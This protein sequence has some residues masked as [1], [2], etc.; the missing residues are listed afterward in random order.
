MTMKTTSSRLFLLLSCGQAFLRQNLHRL[1]YGDS[2]DAGI[3]IDPSVIVERGIFRR[4]HL[5]QFTVG[6]DL[7]ARPRSRF[8][9]PR[10]SWDWGV[11]PGVLNRFVMNYQ[12]RYDRRDNED[13]REG[14]A[15]KSDVTWSEVA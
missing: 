10:Q 15:E 5:A 14:N 9:L 1:V 4:P 13:D 11:L 6:I 2:Y 12:G 3:L 7:Q 8:T